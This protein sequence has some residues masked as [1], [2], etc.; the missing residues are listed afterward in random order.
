[1]TASWLGAVRVHRDACASTNDEAIALARAG[2]AHGTVVTAGAQTAGRGRAGRTWHSPPGDNLYLSIVV[3]SALPAARLP[4][5]TLAAGVGACDAIRAAGVTGARI[6]W[7]NDVLAGD[8]KLAG[9][10]TETVGRTDAVVIG[11]GVDVDGRRDRLP[12]ELA[13]IATSIRDETGVPQ[14]VAAFT[15]LL[16]GHLEPWLDRFLD[17]GVAAVADAWTARADL[18]RR[19]RVVTADG[20]RTGLPVGL[21]PDGALRIRTDAGDE[22]RVIAGDVVEI[23][24]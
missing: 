14:E 7:P 22:L 21:D 4:A 5:V 11:V 19:V 13:A 12:A 2:A 23:A 18:S 3:R 24:G 10:L 20:A 1:V 9:V 17:G 6:K 16:L 15:E 8:R